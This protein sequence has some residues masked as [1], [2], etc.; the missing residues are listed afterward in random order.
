MLK[1]IYTTNKTGVNMEPYDK[2]KVDLSWVNDVYFDTEDDTVIASV[3]VEPLVLFCKEML[4]KYEAG[5][6]DE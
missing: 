2:V 1:C 5:K 3:F 4:E 6:E